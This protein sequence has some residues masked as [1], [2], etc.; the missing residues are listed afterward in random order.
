MFFLYNIIGALALVFF[1]SSLKHDPR[2]FLYSSVQLRTLIVFLPS[3]S[4]WGTS[5]GKE[6]LSL[7]SVTLT[8]WAAQRRGYWNFL[9][10]L[11]SLLLL[12]VIRPHLA[13]LMSLGFL[14]SFFFSFRFISLKKLILSFS[15]FFLTFLYIIPRFGARFDFQTLNISK[16]LNTIERLSQNYSSST[17]FYS[18]SESNFMEVLFSYLFRPTLLEVK[19]YLFFFS[20]IENLILLIY[21]L[22]GFLAYIKFRKKSNWSKHPFC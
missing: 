21:F 5:I 8:L 1:D 9:Y 17:S 16:A 4:F 2:I 19:N 22:F 12:A 13:L 14:I 15:I 18:I 11:G 20:G 6:P 7:F 10:I 3:L